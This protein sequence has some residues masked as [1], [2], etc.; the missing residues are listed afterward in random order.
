MSKSTVSQICQQLLSRFQAF[1]A[2]SLAEVDLLVLL[3]DAN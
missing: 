2:R 3:L 1:R